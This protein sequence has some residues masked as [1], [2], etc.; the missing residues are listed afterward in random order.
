MLVIDECRMYKVYLMISD[1]FELDSSEYRSL[2]LSGSEPK[3]EIYY[4]LKI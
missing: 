2:M 3:T 4:C 1:N